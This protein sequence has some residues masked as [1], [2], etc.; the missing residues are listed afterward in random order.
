MKQVKHILLCLM[1]MMLGTAC[2]SH[3]EKGPAGGSMPTGNLTLDKTILVLEK[4]M[5][6]KL[7]STLTPDNGGN[8]SIA[9]KSDE[10][11]IATVD[12][13]GKVKAINLGTASITAATNDGRTATCMVKVMPDTSYETT[14]S[15]VY[16]NLNKTADEEEVKAI[17]NETNT[18]GFKSYVVG[19]AFEKLGIKRNFPASE[20][21]YSMNNPFSR[22]NAEVIDLIGVSGWPEVDVDGDNQPDHIT[23]M[24]SHAFSRKNQTNDFKLKE[25]KLPAEVKAIGSEAFYVTELEKINL[26]EVE[27]VGKGAFQ[28]CYSLTTI[29]NLLKVKSIHDNAFYQCHSLK[30]VT[31]NSTDEVILGMESFYQC[32]ALETINFPTVTRIP[33][34]AF[35]G[36]ENLTTFIFPAATKFGH[37]FVHG[38]QL[39]TLKLTAPGSFILMDETTG[40][41]EPI[42]MTKTSI[43]YNFAT[44][45]PNCALTLNSDKKKGGSATPQVIGN[46]GWCW[47]EEYNNTQSILWKSI[48]YV[49]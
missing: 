27:A 23:G 6:E 11:E 40:Q 25:I 16:I 45:A 8:V 36:C 46:N 34:L 5:E 22:T 12:A 32:R 26:N 15:E 17:I 31:I 44:Y 13:D 24:P 39:T 21:D 18:A 28:Y 43:F 42:D 7:T 48:H 47:Y 9:W 49:D 10:P 3:D 2:S 41:S 19:G 33:T 14:E 35:F 1:A 29:I 38:E 20:T 4:N 30:E 37:N